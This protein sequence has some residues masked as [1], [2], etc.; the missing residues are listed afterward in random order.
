MTKRHFEALA[1]NLH[2]E[3]KGRPVNNPDWED[4]FKAAVQQVADTCKEANIRFDRDRFKA[5]VYGEE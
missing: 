1:Y 5:A 3:W 2:L 4:G